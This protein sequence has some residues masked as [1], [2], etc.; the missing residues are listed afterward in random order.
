MEIISGDVVPLLQGEA[1]PYQAIYW[2][3]AWSPDGRRLCFKGFK[4]DGTSEVASIST[5][6]EDPDLSVHFSGK[7][8]INADF[9]WHPKGDRIIFAMSCPERGF[10]QLYEFDPGKADPPKLV[11][12]QDITRNNTDAC[13]TPDG[14]RLI[15]ISGDF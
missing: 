11:E 1:N 9:A 14:K 13:W 8:N 5:S 12:G 2:N 6:G 3:S 4:S 7:I 10:V 15:V